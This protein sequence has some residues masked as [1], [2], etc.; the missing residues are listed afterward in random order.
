[1]RTYRKC[2]CVYRKTVFR[3]KFRRARNAH[4]KAQ[5]TPFTALRLCFKAFNKFIV[6]FCIV[7][8]FNYFDATAKRSGFTEPI[9]LPKP[10]FIFAF[11][12]NVG[13]A[14]KYGYIEIFC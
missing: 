7:F 5:I 3:G 9:K 14:E 10:L 12:C 1:M 11:I 13:I 4:F 6:F 2:C 8:V